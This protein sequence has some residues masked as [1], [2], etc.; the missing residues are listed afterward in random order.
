[1]L[2]SSK[3]AQVVTPP[4]RSS[5]RAQG[6][7]VEHDADGPGGRDGQGQLLVT[8]THR[9]AR[10][11]RAA[12]PCLLQPTLVPRDVD[13]KAAARA[14]A[15]NRAGRPSLGQGREKPNHTGVALQEHFADAGDAA[16]VAV[17]LKRGMSVEKV[18]I[19]P[20]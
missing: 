6:G 18:G 15:A 12:D 4:R 13:P 17:D 10:P 8:I 16:E 5:H 19:R 20:L 7:T 2:N 11:E 9:T 3:L 1:M 14:E